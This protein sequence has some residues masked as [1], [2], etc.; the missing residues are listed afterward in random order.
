MIA[1]GGDGNGGLDGR[2]NADSEIG[3]A[4]D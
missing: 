1:A 4:D 2:R 3:I